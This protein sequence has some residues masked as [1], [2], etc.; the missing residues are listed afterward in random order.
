MKI[1]SNSRQM[2]SAKEI[3][4][5]KNYCDLLYA[6]LQCNSEKV[7]ADGYDRRI[8]KVKVK[9]TVIEKDFTRTCLDGSVEKVMG[10]KTIAKYF[11][12]LVDTGLVVDEGDNYYYIRLLG[13][14]EANLIEY[15]TLSKLMNVL[16][17]NSIS[18]YIYL[19]NRFY[20][21]GCDTFV[22][23]MRQIK[24]YIGIATTTTS[25]NLIVSDT[26][27]ILQRLGLLEMEMV[28]DENEMKSHMNFKWVANKLP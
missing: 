15:E 17:K 26:I 6:W 10:R 12:F 4:R 28:F 5:E 14:R 27:E 7:Y 1:E 3:T 11:Q 20:A 8:E 23:T 21:N 13:Q 22:A 25:N 24:E 19:F 18:I 9:W 16:Q 2:P